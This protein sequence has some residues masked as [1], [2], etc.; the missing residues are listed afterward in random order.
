VAVVAAAG[1]AVVEVAAVAGAAVGLV[2]A[3]TD[4]KGRRPFLVAF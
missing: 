2:A 4:S 3:T 1:A